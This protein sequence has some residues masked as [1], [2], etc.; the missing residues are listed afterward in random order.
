MPH[1]T[2]WGLNPEPSHCSVPLY[3]PWL[4]P[5]PEGPPCPSWGCTIDTLAP[6]CLSTL[7]QKCTPDCIPTLPHQLPISISSRVPKFIH[8]P[9]TRTPIRTPPCSWPSPQGHH[10]HTPTGDTRPRGA[11]AQP[12]VG[13]KA[14]PSP[15]LPT[16]RNTQGLSWTHSTQDNQDTTPLPSLH[17]RALI[18]EPFPAPQFT[19]LT[20]CPPSE[21]LMGGEG[22]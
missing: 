19:E 8:M 1:I 7:S 9:P 13:A 16:L 6:T 22:T 4:A 2:W 17:L 5:P 15:M 20:V 12:S 10:Q 21:D 3:R 11:K 14:Q 18:L